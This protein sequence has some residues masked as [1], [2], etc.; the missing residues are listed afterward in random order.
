MDL[1]PTEHEY[2]RDH[3]WGLLATGRRNGSPQVSMVAYDWDGNDLVISCRSQT[4]KYINATRN[5]NVVFSVPDDL[6]NLTV[7]GTA[8]CHGSGPERDRLTMRLRDRLAHGHRWASDILDA[9]SA[10]G[11]DETDRVVIQIVPTEIRLLRPQ[12]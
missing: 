2:L 10:A 11:L 4:A 1:G 7:T 12:G 9:D 6:D 5:E 3:V 8:I